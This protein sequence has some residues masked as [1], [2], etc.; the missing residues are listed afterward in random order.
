MR[1]SMRTGLSELVRTFFCAR[2][3][4][5]EAELVFWLNGIVSLAVGISVWVKFEV[6]LGAAVATCAMTFVL[7]LCSL[8]HPYSA[9][10]GAAG[11]SLVSGGIGA[12]IGTALGLRYLGPPGGWVG[13]VAAG[14]GFLIG[15]ASAY[16]RLVH[17]VREA[18]LKPGSGGS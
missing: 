6:S 10:V 17:A 4:E 8:L 2:Q 11:G 15:A 3:H 16:R 9:I 13:G 18:R 1:G 14:V 5:T 12:L 7:L